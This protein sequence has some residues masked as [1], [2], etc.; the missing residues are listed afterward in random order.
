LPLIVEAR[1]CIRDFALLLVCGGDKEEML[2]RYHGLGSRLDTAL[3]QAG[4]RL[5]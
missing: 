1:N 3:R 5:K 2:E 4:A